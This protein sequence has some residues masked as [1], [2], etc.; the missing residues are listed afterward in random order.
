MY[1][2]QDLSS[3]FEIREMMR[4]EEEENVRVSTLL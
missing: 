2:L 3:I 4:N 1:I